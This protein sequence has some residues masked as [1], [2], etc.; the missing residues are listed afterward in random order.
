[1]TKGKF[2]SPGKLLLTSEYVVLDGAQALALPTK[3]GQE[4]F[5]EEGKDDDPVIV[6]EAFH[7]NKAWLKTTINYKSWEIL[8]ANLPK[9]A[10][11]VLK[12]LKSACEL[13]N[14][15]FQ[16]FKAYHLSTNLQFPPDYGLGSSSTLMNNVAQWA[17]ADAFQ[18][19]D[20]LLGGSGYDIAVAKAH[21][22]ILY[23]KS[24]NQIHYQSVNFKPNYKSDLIFVHLNQKMDSR[25]GISQYREKTVNQ[26]LISDFS[27]LT[28]KILDCGNIETFGELMTLHE[29]KISDIIDIPPLKK[30]LFSDYGG[31]IKSL[32]AWGGDFFLAS[33]VGDY[34]NYFKER[35]YH[36]IFEYEDLIV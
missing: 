17:D 3:W 18:L 16:D 27:E 6:W 23:C 9:A 5:F 24:K 4:F 20:K 8:D 36:R 7:Q 22:P 30:E 2:F 26:N 31:F 11:F 1:M 14:K 19:N 13:S 21:T 25:K 15:R 34:Q 32:G 33:K 35:N 28:R 29:E 12:V 10:E